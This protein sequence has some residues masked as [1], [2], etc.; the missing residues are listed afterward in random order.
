VRLAVRRLAIE[1]LKRWTSPASCG[2]HAAKPYL[3]STARSK[4]LLVHCNDLCM[5]IK[6][7][8]VTAV[9]KNKLVA[10]SNVQLRAT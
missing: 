10:A 8:L 4:I 7:E 2:S 9:L 5:R 6:S 3:E 1:R